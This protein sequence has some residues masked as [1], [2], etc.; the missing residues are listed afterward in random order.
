MPRNYLIYFIIAS[1]SLS[2]STTS[3]KPKPLVI[4]E[5]SEKI[6][7][8]R[9][10]KLEGAK[11]RL[12]EFSGI[13]IDIFYLSGSQT[14]EVKHDRDSSG[15]ELT[16]FLDSIIELKTVRLWFDYKNLNKKPEEGVSSLTKIL[17][18]RN[19]QNQCI[20][21][22]RYPKELQQFNNVIATSY[23]ISY[24]EI[25]QTKIERDFLFQNRFSGI[26]EHNV[27]T[28]STSFEMFDFMQ[29]YFPD[30]NCNYWMS[31]NLND[32]QLELLA[33]MAMKP[34]V[35]IILVDGNRNFLK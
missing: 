25:P 12:E 27:S 34:N 11:G 8:H 15:I 13:E 30:L 29:E 14:F 19:L 28:L 33:K 18:D 22:S 21:E 5:P 17:V 23:W 10:N 1:A 31:G 6:W 7:A 35:N 24:A 3:E 16:R 9:F 2:C 32:E 20:I 4:I 26:R